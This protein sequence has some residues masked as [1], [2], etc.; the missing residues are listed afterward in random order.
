MMRDVSMTPSN[1]LLAN[2]SL[3]L[4]IGLPN[5]KARVTFIGLCSEYQN[6]SQNLYSPSWMSQR[7]ERQE[8]NT[9]LIDFAMKTQKSVHG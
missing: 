3:S 4:Q 8:Y 1:F 6:N 5:K 9:E 7:K 2:Q